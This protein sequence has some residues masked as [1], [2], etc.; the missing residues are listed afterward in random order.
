MIENSI[1]CQNYYAIRRSVNGKGLTISSQR[2]YA[3]YFQKFLQDYFKKPYISCLK[4]YF[5]NPKEFIK[6]KMGKLTK[7]LKLS[8]LFLGPFKMRKNLEFTV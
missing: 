8:F 5:E 1:E 2:R 4:E 7:K 6:E 3:Y